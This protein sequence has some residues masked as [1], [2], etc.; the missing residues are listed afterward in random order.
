MTAGIG[1]GSQNVKRTYEDIFWYSDRPY[2]K[3][4]SLWERNIATL[5]LL[6][7]SNGIP[8][9]FIDND[10]AR[11]LP[12]KYDFDG[13]DV[14][15]F[16]HW[17]R[18]RVGELWFNEPPLDPDTLAS[19]LEVARILR[20]TKQSVNDY[21][22]MRDTVADIEDLAQII[23]SLPQFDRNRLLAR[24]TIENTEPSDTQAR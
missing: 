13:I 18:Y 4:S 17:G 7:E 23:S 10:Y 5:K 20:D 9:D 19:D 3:D 1:E 11:G 14:E 21:V 6:L 15:F 16:P 8:I 2:I 22:T 12:T 24:F